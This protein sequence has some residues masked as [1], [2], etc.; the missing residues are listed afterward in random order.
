MS[1]ALVLLVRMAFVGFPEIQEAVGQLLS[2]SGWLVGAAILVE[3]LWTFS[4]A[5]VYRSSLIAF[6]GRIDR[7]RAVGIRWERSR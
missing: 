4:L 7:S 5:N 3:A 1:L 6:G 2:R